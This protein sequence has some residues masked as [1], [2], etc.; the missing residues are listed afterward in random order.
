M[1]AGAVAN[2]LGT[3]PLWQVRQRAAYEPTDWSDASVEALGGAKV[4]T[5]ES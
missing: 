3:A 5:S 2:P 4:A 1:L